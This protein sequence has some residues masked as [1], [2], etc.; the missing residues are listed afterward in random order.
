VVNPD[1]EGQSIFNTVAIQAPRNSLGTVGGIILLELGLIFW[2]CNGTAVA[3]V[4][5]AAP[6]AIANSP[7]RRIVLIFT[8]LI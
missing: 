6:E 3:I 8:I 4:G 7:L 2:A 1:L 5:I